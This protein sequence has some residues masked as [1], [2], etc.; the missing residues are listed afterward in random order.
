MKT[1]KTGF[2]LPT[3]IYSTTL[4]GI[5]LDKDIVINPDASLLKYI[6][7]FYCIDGYLDLKE[8][9]F[10]GKIHASV[11]CKTYDTHSEMQFDL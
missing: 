6:P 3:Y 4:G 9:E 2:L 1:K 10:S 5:L 8:V 11:Y 7:C